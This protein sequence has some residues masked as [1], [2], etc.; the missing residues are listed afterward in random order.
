MAH[1]TAI[2]VRCF[3]WLDLLITLCLSLA[4]RVDFAITQI[5]INSVSFSIVTRKMGFIIA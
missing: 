1:F 5:I 3:K 4:V 2:F